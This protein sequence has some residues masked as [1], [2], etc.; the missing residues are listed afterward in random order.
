MGVNCRLGCADLSVN[1]LDNDQIKIDFRPLYQCVHIHEALDSKAELQRNYQEDRKV[2]VT[3]KTRA[4]TNQTQADLIMAARS[5]TNPDTLMTTLPHLMQELVGFFIIE[6]HV[7]KS[8][9]DFRSQ[10][11]VDDL[12]D[13]MCRRII[14]VVSLGLKGCS[15]L[16]VFLESKTNILLFVQTLE[17]SLEH[18]AQSN[19]AGLRL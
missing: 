13:E 18:V 12:W 4:N 8:V 5:A 1:A 6:A 17:V 9:T 16:N 19:L 7:L 15:D 3:L 11:D 14:G 2:C 10:R